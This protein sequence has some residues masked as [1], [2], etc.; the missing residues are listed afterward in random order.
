MRR[1]LKTDGVFLP[2]A[3]TGRDAASQ[4]GPMTK[5]SPTPVRYMLQIRYRNLQDVMRLD[6]EGRMNRPGRAEGNWAW[7]VGPPTVWKSLAKE[8]STL[9]AMAEVTASCKAPDC[10]QPVLEAYIRGPS[11]EASQCSPRPSTAGRLHVVAAAHVL[12]EDTS[13][14]WDYMSLVRGCRCMTGCRRGL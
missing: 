8:A 3:C 12:R 2:H 9:K 5:S 1:L 7:R 11:F 10:P 6:N 4:R 14:S 13:A